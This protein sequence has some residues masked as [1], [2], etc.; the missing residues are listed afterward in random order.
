MFSSNQSNFLKT[1]L[2]ALQTRIASGL[3][4]G[5]SVLVSAS[6]S[7]FSGSVLDTIQP[8]QKTESGGFS[9]SSDDS[10][11]ANGIR[12]DSQSRRIAALFEAAAYIWNLAGDEGCV[13]SVTFQD[14]THGWG[15]KTMD[16]VAQ[17]FFKNGQLVCKEVDLQDRS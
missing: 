2:A 11:F 3:S 16:Y 1:A 12:L 7:T 14:N 10:Q 9:G 17:V 8:D 15:G 6:V 13:V 5:H 4:S